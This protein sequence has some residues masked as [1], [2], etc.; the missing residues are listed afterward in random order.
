VASRAVAER[1]PGRERVL[2]V[3]TGPLARALIEAIESRGGS[4]YSIAGVADNP[5]GLGEAPLRYPLLGPLA[6]LGKI[7]DQTRPDRLI[8]ALPER[9]GRLPVR[10]LLDARIW[11]GRV[12]EDAAEAYER[13]TGKVAI[14]ALAPSSLI[15]SNHF[16]RSRA[17]LAIGRWMSVLA[18]LVGLG[19]LFPLLG[20][21]AL[22]IKLD[23]RGPVFF[24]QDRVGLRGRRFRLIKFRTMRPADTAAS[25]W[26]RDNAR[27]ITRVGKWLRRFRLDELPQFVNILRG[28]MNLVGPRPHPVSNVELF[29]ERIPYYALRSAVRPGITGWAQIRFGYANDLEE[30]TE[31]MRYDLYYIKHLSPWLDVRI[32]LDTVR[33]VLLGRGAEAAAAGAV[34]AAEPLVRRARAAEAAAT[35]SAAV[36]PVR[37]PREKVA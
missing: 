34:P 10:P 27:R 35:G 18:A 36:E 7:I 2:I 14:E 13:L 37:R 11:D 32:L 8:L 3:G 9:R 25:E 5:G 33:I 21:I 23:S 30:E 16:R 31:K 4:R 26:V 28:D 6:H 19:V 12:I 15:F 20:L 24:T 17:A 29:L 22:A 1:R